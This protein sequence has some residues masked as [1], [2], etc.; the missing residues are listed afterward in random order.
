MRIQKGK[1]VSKICFWYKI[2]TATGPFG[3]PQS[4]ADC[5]RLKT[6]L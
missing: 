1:S 6:A 4:S 5:Y 2:C 3:N